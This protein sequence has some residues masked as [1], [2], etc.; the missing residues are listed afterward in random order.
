MSETGLIA[1]GWNQLEALSLAW[2][3]SGLGGLE[4]QVY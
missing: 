2:L 4:N 1:G 3:A